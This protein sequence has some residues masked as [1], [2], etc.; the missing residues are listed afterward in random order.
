[1][2]RNPGII[3]EEEFSKYTNN[4]P[5]CLGE[6]K[7]YATCIELTFLESLSYC[8]DCDILRSSLMSFPYLCEQCNSPY[9]YNKDRELKDEIS[10]EI[11]KKYNAMDKAGKE[12]IELLETEIKNLREA[13]PKEICWYCGSEDFISPTIEE[14]GKMEKNNEL[15]IGYHMYAKPVKRE[16]CPDRCNLS[17]TLER[18]SETVFR[19]SCKD[20]KSELYLGVS[21]SK[22][23]EIM[24]LRHTQEYPDFITPEELEESRN[25]NISVSEFTDFED[26]KKKTIDFLDETIPKVLKEDKKISLN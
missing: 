11:I 19:I 12:E 3:S 25:M 8:P 9:F 24:S 4:C 1:M 17:E 10:D 5:E 16:L 15:K 21:K 26:L 14:F 13:E 23:L 7:F 20:C 18:A 22:Q 2:H 6:L